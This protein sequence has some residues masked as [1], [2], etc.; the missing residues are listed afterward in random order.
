ML[1]VPFCVPPR[2]SVDRAEILDSRA[3]TTLFLVVGRYAV[4]DRCAA[5]DRC[6]AVDRCVVVDRCAAADRCVVVD[7]CVVMGRC[8]AVDRCVEDRSAV[9]IGESPT[10]PEVCVFLSALKVVQSSEILS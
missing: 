2:T 5:A 1:L 10:L 8:V 3:A 6:A 4:V 9:Q 7:R